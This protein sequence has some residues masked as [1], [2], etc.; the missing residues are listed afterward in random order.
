MVDLEPITLI[1]VGGIGL[2][3]L[4]RQ[5]IG[6][7]QSVG[8]VVCAWNLA[9]RQLSAEHREEILLSMIILVL[10]LVVYVLSL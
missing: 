5:F 9:F 7:L 6:V 4:R 3:L 8:R 10:C 2:W 1:L